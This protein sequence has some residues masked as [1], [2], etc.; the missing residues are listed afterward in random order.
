MAKR[1]GGGLSD[2]AV[3]CQLNI[4]W[5]P[6]GRGKPHPGLDIDGDRYGSG[7][8]EERLDGG[9]EAEVVEDRRMEGCRKVPELCRD[10]P[11]RFS[12]ARGVWLLF[13]FQDHACEGLKRP[14]VQLAGEPRPLCL[15]CFDR[16]PLTLLFENEPIHPAT[17]RPTA[18]DSDTDGT[19]QDAR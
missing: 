6:V 19:D 3:G 16:N 14:V 1:I 9:N 15:G 7:F 17:R 18:G 8:S 5:W 12:P 2:D 10:R 11:E 13:E 4:E